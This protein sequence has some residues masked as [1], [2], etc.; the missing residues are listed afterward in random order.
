MFFLRLHFPY[1]VSP[2]SAQDISGR[3]SCVFYW[4]HLAALCITLLDPSDLG[5]PTWSLCLWHCRKWSRSLQQLQ[6]L[7]AGSSATGLM[8]TLGGC[9]GTGST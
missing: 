8:E 1:Q 2:S 4:H 3:S 5:R 9:L 6:G 7:L